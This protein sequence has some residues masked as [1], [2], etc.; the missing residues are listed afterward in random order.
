MMFSDTARKPA[1]LNQTRASARR[2]KPLLSRKIWLPKALYA[3]LPYFYLTTGVLA[4]LA[5]LYISHWLWLLPHYLIFSVACLH[6]GTLIY[7]RRHRDRN[8]G[9]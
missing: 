9:D 1:T 8:D 2:S 7:R 4:L 6:M 3:L 5:T